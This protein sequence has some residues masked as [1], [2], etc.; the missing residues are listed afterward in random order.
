MNRNFP[1]MHVWLR[2]TLI[3]FYDSL[4]P[5]VAE[6]KILPNTPPNVFEARIIPQSSKASPIWA[7]GEEGA[8][9]ANFGFGKAS[10]FEARYYDRPDGELCLKESVMSICNAI[11]HN[12]WVEKLLVRGN[13]V[14]KSIALLPPPVGKVQ[15]TRWDIFSLTWLKR[16][17]EIVIEW[18]PYPSK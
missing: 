10:A 16:K 13:T 3:Q 8:W 2:A 9:E 1:P 17:E 6:L 11:A 14:M 5:S 7:Y 4:P 15:V 12:A 18:E